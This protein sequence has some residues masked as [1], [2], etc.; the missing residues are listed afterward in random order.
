[1]S[2]SHHPYNYEM[3][4]DRIAQQMHISGLEH[5]FPEIYTTDQGTAL[6]KCLALSKGEMEGSWPLEDSDMD[7]YREQIPP[8][9]DI[10]FANLNTMQLTVDPASTV[11]SPEDVGLHYDMGQSQLYDDSQ[12]DY[13]DHEYEDNDEDCKGVFHL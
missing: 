6:A 12:S 3:V 1:M 8:Y 4:V 9:Q 13:Y 11:S 5:S 2:M 10:N 7:G